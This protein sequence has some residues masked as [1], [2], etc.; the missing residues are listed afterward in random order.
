MAKYIGY[1]EA[2]RDFEGGGIKRKK[3]QGYSVTDIGEIA[4][5]EPGGRPDIP[6]D[7]NA[8][9][10]DFIRTPQGKYITDF[11][12]PE[13]REDYISPELR[14]RGT[15]SPGFAD[16]TFV[17]DESDTALEQ[18]YNTTLDTIRNEY[19][20]KQTILDGMPPGSP[21]HQFLSSRNVMEQEQK[22]NEA[23]IKYQLAKRKF[24][25]LDDDNTIDPIQ[26]NL[27]KRQILAK[28]FKF[29]L[30]SVK[31]L[32]TRQQTQL[33]LGELN[34]RID[35]LDYDREKANIEAEILFGLNWERT[36][37]EVKTFIDSKFAEKEK[38]IINISEPG[39]VIP[40]VGKG[41]YDI[42]KFKLKGK[43]DDPKVIAKIRKK[44]KEYQKKGVK[45]P[46]S[47]Q[48]FIDLPK[49]ETD[50]DY[51]ALKS[52]QEFIAPDGT[53]RRKP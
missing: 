3:G 26:T 42:S 40:G 51:D 39:V 34:Q 46:K 16:N 9:A 23:D 19:L 7:P 5:Y 28:T 31:P 30:P 47:M 41:K 11:T 36:V 12:K 6:R 20:Q 2:S 24:Q 15:F 50:A 49:V 8:P 10:G 45:V 17:K 21:Q 33:K 35:S 43:R 13:I 27:A 52:G 4:P 29:E 48:E 25:D 22:F 37:P 14:R 32:F 1:V 18:N 44:I 53:T 38:N